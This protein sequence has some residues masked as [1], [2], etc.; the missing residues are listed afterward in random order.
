MIT[1]RIILVAF[2]ISLVLAFGID[3]LAQ[4][5]PSQLPQLRQ[6]ALNLLQAQ[7]YEEAISA[8]QQILKTAP[9]DE[10]ALYN[11]ACAYSLWKKPDEAVEYLQKAVEAGF[12]D[13]E[14]I[15]SDPDLKNIKYH[16]GYKKIIQ[17]KEE[18][19]KKAAGKKIE[20]LKKQY[21]KS[22]TYEIDEKRKLIYASDASEKLLDKIQEFL[23]KFAD[24]ERTYIFKNKPTYYITILVPSRADFTKMV[25]NP[26]IGG[27]YSHDNKTLICRDTGQTLR[28]EFTHAL[29]FADISARKQVHPIWIT[30]GLATCFEDS[31]IVYSSLVPKYNE[32]IDQ[33]KSLITSTSKNYIPWQTLM[34]MEQKSFMA[35]AG[36][37]YAESRAICYWLAK[38]GKLKSFYDNYVYDLSANST[39]G[40]IELY[41]SS[42]GIKTLE[43][44]FGKKIEEIEEEWKKWIATTQPTNVLDNQKGTFVGLGV[45]ASVAGMIITKVEAGSPAAEAGLKAK[46]VILKIGSDKTTTYDEFANAIRKR[47]PGEIVTFYILREDKEQQIKVKLGKRE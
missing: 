36:E 10:I 14:H 42:F 7:K 28:H 8:Y 17:S 6:E 15:E 18:I 41:V 31:E 12:A 29:H 24:A 2:L 32:R 44:I 26:R 25:P 3:S 22:Y 4:D 1:K 37:C 47:S 20:S 46:D 30:E 27:F 21:G 13:F 11:I 23:N 38:T 40:G 33:T 5:A 39:K 16:N 45:E 35:K 43:K 9:D 34:K 19:Q